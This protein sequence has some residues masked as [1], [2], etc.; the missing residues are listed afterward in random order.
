MRKKRGHG[1]PDPT[2]CSGH[3]F[4]IFSCGSCSGGFDF[5]I[6][7]DG[8]CFWILFFGF[9]FFFLVFHWLQRLFDDV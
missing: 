2:H 7:S 4:L 8:S 6:F 5:F 9:F 1:R 3:Y